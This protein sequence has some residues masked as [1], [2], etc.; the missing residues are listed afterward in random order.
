MSGNVP[1]VLYNLG[2]TISSIDINNPLDEGR[3]DLDSHADTCV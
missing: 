3:L 1:T 2:N